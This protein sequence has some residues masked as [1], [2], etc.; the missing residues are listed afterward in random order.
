MTTVYD[1]SESNAYTILKGLKVVSQLAPLH[2]HILHVVSYTPHQDRIPPSHPSWL[3]LTS[4][5]NN[6][7]GNG[8][9]PK[10]GHGQH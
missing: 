10:S 7:L 4:S 1:Y 2:L 5:L 9:P 6:F 8:R 3:P